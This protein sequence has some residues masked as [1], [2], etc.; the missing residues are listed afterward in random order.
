M[1][2]A[3]LPFSACT[4]GCCHKKSHRIP[5]LQVFNLITTLPQATALLFLHVDSTHFPADSGPSLR[6]SSPRSRRARS[7]LHRRCGPATGH[8]RRQ[9]PSPM[10]PIQRRIPFRRPW[11]PGSHQRPAR[12]HPSRRLALV[13]LLLDQIRRSHGRILPGRRC[14]RHRCRVPALPRRRC[15]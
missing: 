9:R 11:P 3:W 6:T 5:A 15:R 14:G 4:P 8:S 1:Q 7:M 10:G 13:A 12:P 2:T